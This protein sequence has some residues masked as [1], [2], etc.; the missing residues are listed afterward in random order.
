MSRGEVKN[1]ARKG[2]RAIPPGLKLRHTFRGHKRAINRIAWSPNGQMVSSPSSDKSIRL[3]DAETGEL[4]RTLEGH[5][6]WVYCAAWSP[7][8]KT[9]ASGSADRTLRI[10]DTTTGELSH[11]LLGHSERVYTVVWSPDGKMFA[12]GSMDTRILIWNANARKLTREL[13]GPSYW[14]NALAWSPDGRTLAS[15]GGE[16]TIQLWDVETWNL[17]RTLDGHSSYIVSLDWSRDGKILASA[18]YDRT[19]RLWDRE[20][21]RQEGILE[22]HSSFVNCVSFSADNLFLAS[23][24]NDGTVRIWRCDT[25]ETAVVLEE[26]ASGPWFSEMELFSDELTRRWPSGIAFHPERFSLATL[27]GNET[28]VRIWELDLAELLGASQEHST[29]HYRNAKVV[30]VGD[31][32]VGKSGL[33]LVLTGETFRPTESTHGRY[34]W[35]FDSQEFRLDDKRWETREILLWDLAGQP[36]YRLIHQLHLNEVAIGLVVFDARSETDPFSGVRHWDRSLRQ[37]RRLQGDSS[38]RLKKFL[39][40]ARVDRTGIGVSRTRIDALVHDLGFDDFFETSAKENLDVQRLSEAIRLSID[41]EALPKVTSTR[42][43]QDIKVFLVREKDSGRLIGGVG[44]LYADFAKSGNT[45]VAS[46]GL[47][48]Q[49]ET[50]IG[51]LESQGLVRWLGFGNLILLQPE[52]L[53]AYASAIVNAA[54]DE[55]EGTGSIAEEDV[56]EGRFRMADDERVKNKDQEKLLL[57]ATV[58]EMLRHEIALREPAEEKQYLVFPSQ[59]TRENPDLPDPQGKA[60]IF[61]FE[62]ALANIYAT[63]AV[64]LSHS[65]AFTKKDM[66]RNAVTYTAVEGGTCGFFL[67]EI[68][69]GRGELALYFDEPASEATRYQFEEFIESHL[70]RRALTESISRRRLFHCSVCATPVTELAAQR[71]RA[72]GFQWIDCNVCG[73]R[74]SL[75]DGVARLTTTPESIVVEMDRAADAQCQRGTGAT[76]LQGKIATSDFDVFLSYNRADRD[77]VKK[78]AESLRER[79]ILPWLDEEQLRPG[80]P[81][82]RALGKQIKKI[83]SAA[84]FVGPKGIGP[85]QKREQEAFLEEFVNRECPVIPAILPGC[86]R[87]PRLPI[88]LKA[89]SWVDFRKDDPAPLEQLIWG[90]TGERRPL[91]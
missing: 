11:T 40:A 78:I 63:L 39:V 26:P 7:D 38:S 42:L 55:P 41:W 1:V 61:G 88:L 28:L 51:R 74:L 69:E 19:V 23:K 68:E 72:R 44:D 35:T 62:G 12:S 89:M 47:L 18:S 48:A 76:I 31:T 65:G 21:G 75:L 9:L 80:L 33:G 49:F 90:I 37:A 59:F 22:G 10:W 52:R 87:T 50:C 54:K 60:V 57:I 4:C 25:W 53:D 5:T 29:V 91:P 13:I 17:R 14:V 2:H 15:G 3:W 83:R 30:L 16:G 45:S 82:Q 77:E 32:G 86:T 6:G 36:G 8:G 46:E 20:T 79:G 24:S 84:V 81:W 58:E 66:W 85:W 34:V 70:R 43:F 27:G 73:E 67:R 64:R 56:L 71:R